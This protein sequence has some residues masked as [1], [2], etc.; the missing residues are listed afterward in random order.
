MLMLICFSVG[1]VWAGV[2]DEFYSFIPYKPS[3]GAVSDYTLTGTMTID[4]MEWTVPGNWYGNGA[5]RLGGKGIEGVDRIIT[6]LSP[7]GDKI[8]KIVINHA[9]TTS[10]KITLNAIKVTVASDA[11]FTEDV[12]EISL[13]SGT[14]FTVSKN[15]PGATIEITPAG[16]YWA[17]A[18]YYK[19]AFNI[20]NTNGTNYAFVLNSIQFYSYVDVAT[21][22]IYP[23]DNQFSDELEISINCTTEGADIY[24]TL[25]G[26]DPDA[27]ATLYENPF[28]ITATTTVKAIAFKEGNGSSVAEATYTK[29]E[30]YV[31]PTGYYLIGQDGWTVDAL[32]ENLLFQENSAN[33][34]EYMLTV[35]LV[36]GQEIK[37]VKVEDNTIITW[38]PD[39]NDNNYAVDA[40][41]AGEKTIY[42]RPEGYADW[43]AF[44]EGGFFYIAA[45][46]PV[47]APT[48]PYTLKFNGTGTSS[49]S[50]QSL[51]ADVAAIFTEDCKDL[52]ASVETADK[53][54]AARMIAEEK[55]SLKLGTTSVKGALEFTLAFPQEVDYIIVNATQYGDNASEITVNG[56]AFTLNAGN[57]VP[58]DCKFVPSG[59][60]S[61]IKIEQSSSERLY[62]RYITIYPK[63]T[64]PIEATISADNI[65]LGEVETEDDVFHKEVTL[66][67]TGANLT[68]PITYA[69]SNPDVV[70]VS[71]ELTAEG[72]EL[73]VVIN[74]PA[75]AAGLALDETITLTSGE[76]VLTVAVTANVKKVEPAEPLESGYYLIGQ[77]GWD[78]AALNENLKFQAN[79]ENEGEYFLNVTLFENQDIKV[80]EVASDEIIAWFPAGETPN[81]TVDAS[82]AGNKTV[83][84]RPE[85][86]LDWVTFHDGGFFYIE[87][88]EVI[89][90]APAGAT[91]KLVTS[92]D[93]LVAGAHYV[94]GTPAGSFMSTESNNTNRRITT[95]TVTNDLVTATEA[96]MVFTLGG[97]ANGW[98]FATE[99]Y[100]GTNGYL[101]ATDAT[102][103]NYL[104]VVAALDVYA[105]FSIA[106]EEGVTTVACTGKDSRH[107]LYQNGT[108]C[109]ACYNNQTSS[110]YTKPSLFK[111]VE[112]DIPTPDLEDG[113]YLIGQNG[114][115]ENA[116]S[117]DLLFQ[118]NTENEGEYLLS[119]TLE[120]NQEI[121]V[122]EV[123]DN[124]IKTWFPGGE[125]P[126]YAVDA[127][128]AGEKVVYFRPEGWNDW[129]AFHDGGFF[130]I[131]ANAVIPAGAQYKLVTSADELVEGAHYVIG[132]PAGSFI[133][134]TANNNNRK[135]TTAT[136]EN[137]IV[138]ATDEV[139]VF[140]LGGDAEGWT[141]ATENYLGDA[142]YLNATSATGSNNL[143]VV[144]AL[145]EYAYFTIAI[146]EGVTTVTC[147]GKESR[148]ILYQNGNTCFS[149]YNNQTAQQYIKPNLYKLV[150]G[151]TPSYP[152]YFLKNNWGEGIE[153]TWK[154]TTRDDEGIYHLPNVVY[155]G[156]GINFN[157][158]ADDEGAEFVEHDNI[159]IISSSKAPAKLL[160]C[161]TVN[162]SLDPNAKTISAQILNTNQDKYTVMGSDAGLFFDEWQEGEH[163]S[164][165]TDMTKQEDGTYAWGREKVILFEGIIELQVVKNHDK[166]LGCWPAE[167]YQLSIPST[168]K[169][170]V[171][172]TFNPSTKEVN[173]TADWAEDINFMELNLKGN[174]D[175]SE[176]N[177]LLSSNDEKYKAMVFKHLSA[178]DHQFKLVNQANQW[179]GDKQEFSRGNSSIR[180]IEAVGGEDNNMILHA[181]VEGDYLFIWEYETNHLI[182]Q[183]PSIV[184]TKKAAHLKGKF[185]VSATQQINF[186]RGNLQ[187]NYG[188]EAWYFAENQYER[189]GDANNRFGE[190]E[191]NGTKTYT[192]SIDLFGWSSAISEYGLKASALDADFTGNFE[193]WGGLFTTEDPSRE[194]RTLSKSEWNYL[195]NRTN[196]W[197]MAA[198]GPDSI[199]G[200][201]LFPDEWTAPEGITIKYAVPSHVHDP[202][203]IADD[204]LFTFEQWASLEANGAV[205]LPVNGERAGNIGNTIKNGVSEVANTMNDLTGWYCW[206][207]NIEYYGMYWLSSTTSEKNADYVTLPAWSDGPS[208]STEE[209]DYYY[210]PA[211][212]SRER[213][214]GN[215]VRLVANVVPPTYTVAGGSTA[216]FATAWDETDTNF[217]MT[218]QEDGT[219]QLTLSNIELGVSAYEYKV[220]EDHSWDVSYPIIEGNLN[221]SFSVEASAFYDITFIY[222]PAD[223]FP[224]VPLNA[225][226]EA[227]LTRVGDLPSAQIKGSWEPWITPA[228]T[229]GDAN[230]T[231]TYTRYL[232]AGK[233]YTFTIISNGDK[234]GKGQEFSESTNSHDNIEKG[235]GMKLHTKAAGNYTFTWTFATQSLEI[236][237]P[238][239]DDVYN[240]IGSDVVFGV[241]W[242]YDNTANEMSLNTDGTYSYQIAEIELS[243][244]VYE[245]RVVKNH[246]G[247][248]SYPEY[249]NATFPITVSGKYSIL[250]TLDPTN[251]DHDAAVN[252]VPTLIEPTEIKPTI[253]MKGS[254][255]NWIGT[256]TL[257][258]DNENEASW[259]MKMTQSAS[260]YEFKMLINGNY[261]STGGTITQSSTTITNIVADE[262]GNM[263]LS[264][265]RT[266]N[267]TFTWTYAT[268][269]LTVTYPDD[270]T[271]IGDVDA[272]AKA[273]KVLREGNLFIIKGDKIFNAQGMKVK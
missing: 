267:Y 232:D 255:D 211:V 43:Y 209:D 200:L 221:A 50:G 269:S 241:D 31:L 110:Q 35:T 260:E 1:Q 37:V 45:N 172:I 170:N 144:A 72:G 4:E 145:D 52:V 76:T 245:Y 142:G 179:F 8:A 71:G 177:L 205:F 123:E 169:Y 254:W 234:Y 152:K 20:T 12:E 33:S 106:I 183:F 121:K 30:P 213:R 92:A 138:T 113:F 58:Q 97:D 139:M 246:D 178:G 126:N 141:F 210:K 218:L 220:A 185:S 214:R 47:V 67:V 250:F 242:A 159:Q 108:T 160:L 253:Q 36:A 75:S 196:G 116:L 9:G 112:G 111:M 129:Y 143:K 251:P 17:N 68:S 104:K 252:A 24:Y 180:N 194:W 131:E 216:I 100:A 243:A 188:A 117:A 90:P 225:N 91:Y 151:D 248:G 66:S 167:K 74:A 107:I 10:D 240:V 149:C 130:Y 118:A 192:G 215:S 79:I 229:L 259:T 226:C 272:E 158:V 16:D 127:E 263:K 83:Y 224:D 203:D 202:F 206:V 48:E 81:Y 228:M 239:S 182:I 231:A 268:N 78:K 264:V 54:F 244:D 94:I 140:T 191:Y 198:L 173:A 21:P 187:Y 13:A 164:K 147:T 7:M 137:D 199:L 6:G 38:F 168:A 174:W 150:E 29:E 77:N 186:S 101:N 23:A 64:A 99:N 109:F 236:T 15:T 153:W 46:E 219:Y 227:I 27:N 61:T 190:N 14:D 207:S 156:T 128:H 136:V 125:T 60:L 84:F 103:S 28:T 120:E 262:G 56:T 119:V 189:L 247:D 155:G 39:G 265:P 222:Y 134:T 2:G 163:P 86:N 204:N 233:T 32:S 55:S 114:W 212:W 63:G 42:F 51:A 88:N 62:L 95:A 237:F 59:E 271:A 11:D 40:E 258:Q 249:D 201:I 238:S 165:Q 34:G 89:P 18:S 82:H 266:G 25:D 87:A 44:H 57:K 235:S 157:T 154:E 73:T 22:V 115:D 181:D 5:L 208:T 26:S 176:D 217:D 257:T 105:Y 69:S 193:D 135:I 261:R 146:E 53:I 175:W 223:A 98:T 195:M 49:D 133:A 65:A 270:P 19:F 80:V 122:V 96:M 161:D 230:A 197:T 41:H 171:T 184:P 85:G 273:M 166:T 148:N 162:L 3:S 256:I 93:E 70:A 102:G 132:T 124:A